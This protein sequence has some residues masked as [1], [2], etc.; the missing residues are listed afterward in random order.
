MTGQFI[1]VSFPSEIQFG[2]GD[3][4]SMEVECRVLSLVLTLLLFQEYLQHFPLGNVL[5]HVPEFD[6]GFKLVSSNHT[7]L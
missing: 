5:S 4:L 2:L 3:Y 7:I 6:L 1:P